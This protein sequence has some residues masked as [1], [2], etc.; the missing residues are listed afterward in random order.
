V[1]R[2]KLHLPDDLDLDTIV[3]KR[4]AGRPPVAF[5]EAPAASPPPTAIPVPAE[6][7]TQPGMRQTPDLKAK[8]IA[9]TLYLLPEDH[10][11]LR[12]L[13]ADREVAAQTLL[14]D[15]IDMLFAKSGHG[16]VQRWEPRR[17][18]RP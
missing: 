5:H 2:G 8:A 11:R 18:A 1:A 17:K 13:A 10:R 12:R 4:G 14:L 15:A 6:T 16:P 9:T 3:A 7:V